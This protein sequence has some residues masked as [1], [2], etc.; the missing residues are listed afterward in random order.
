M[1]DPW[2]MCCIRPYSYGLAQQFFTIWIIL[3]I[4]LIEDYGHP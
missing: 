1:P 3:G 2:A 4:D